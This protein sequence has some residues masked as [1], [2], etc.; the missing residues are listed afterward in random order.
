MLY[1]NKDLVERMLNR[2]I[3]WDKT[4]WKESEMAGGGKVTDFTFLKAHREMVAQG[5]PRPVPSEPKPLPPSNGSLGSPS[6]SPFAV[7]R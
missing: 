6:G 7:P 5:P 2:K 1:I 3:D 4:G